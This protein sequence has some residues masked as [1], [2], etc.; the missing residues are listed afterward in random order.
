[1][2]DSVS[3]VK[4][5]PQFTTIKYTTKDGENVTATKKDGVVTLSGDKKGVRQMPL[6]DFVKKELVE[7]L[8]N[9]KLE[10]SPEKDTVELANGKTIEAPKAPEAQVADNKD[11]ASKKLDVAA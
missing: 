11:T 3:A 5:L 10:N 6:D 8:A 2:T 7:N 4:P 9:V 1:M